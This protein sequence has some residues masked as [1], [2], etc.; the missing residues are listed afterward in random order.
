MI[1]E[2]YMRRCFDLAKCGIG[3]VAPNPMVGAVLVFDD[4]IIGEGYH[5]KCGEAHAEVNAIA[6]VS[7]PELLKRATLYVNLEPCSHYGKTPPCAKLIIEKDIP[8]VVVAN[9][10]P[11]P[12]MSGRGIQMLRS[13]GIKVTTGV[14]EKEGWNLNRRFFTFHTQKRPYIILK[15]AQSA[16][17]FMDVKRESAAQP[18]IV[19]SN[20][21]TS[22]MQHKLRSEEAGIMVAT[23]TA[24]LD[25][26]S[27]TARN[28]DG[29][30]NPVRILIDRD[31]KVPM[32]F[33]LYDGAS[34]T[35][36][37]TETE[38][39]VKSPNVEY[40]VLSFDGPNRTLKIDELL[41]ALYQK[42][43][44]SVIVEGGA[45]LL[46]SFMESGLW[47]EMRI[48]TAL[49]MKLKDGVEAPKPCGTLVSEK[50][51]GGHVI[52]WMRN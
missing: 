23:N 29:C 52:Q 10:D 37:F 25:N 30:R 1:D 47:D 14:L 9:S 26:P 49:E 46:H 20:G 4:R 33:K 41:S 35:L 11:F 18:P 3:N 28:W 5:R 51:I 44:Q 6:S 2:A 50:L 22:I 39:L 24:L 8:E 16:D 21:I 17:G 45:A 12:E 36:I 31:L 27:L 38:P 7:K 15:W 48:E 42:S 34:R 40:V 32:S 43:V 13:H 19:I